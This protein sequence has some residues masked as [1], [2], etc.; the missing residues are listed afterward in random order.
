MEDCLKYEEQINNKAYQVY[1][2][3]IKAFLKSGSNLVIFNQFE[4][5]GN[6]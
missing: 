4:E 5:F 1:I 3:L 2:S 6:L